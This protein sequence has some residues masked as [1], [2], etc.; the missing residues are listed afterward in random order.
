LWPA[1]CLAWL[2]LAY[3]SALKVEAVCSSET[4]VTYQVTRCYNLHSHR[5]E[6]L[7]IMM[8][9]TLLETLNHQEIFARIHKPNPIIRKT[10]YTLL[11]YH[12]SLRITGRPSYINNVPISVNTALGI[13]TYAPLSLLKPSIL[14]KRLSWSKCITFSP[15]QLR[16]RNLINL[17]LQ[18]TILAA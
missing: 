17:I 9:Y 7:K 4:S 14:N 12:R 10:T 8:S 15:S 5:F 18:Q 11:Q 3:P 16:L 6:N 13:T 1:H 2:G